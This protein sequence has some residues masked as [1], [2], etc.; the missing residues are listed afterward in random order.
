MPIDLHVHSTASD[1][2]SGPAEVVREAAAA[3]VD[4]LALT[5][6][7]TVAGWAPAA[8]EAGLLGIRLIPG[9]EISCQVRGVSVHLLGYLVDPL[10]TVLTGMWHAT[11]TS[12]ELRARRIVERLAADVPV[13]W[14]DVLAQTDDV[15]TIGRPHIAD[16]LVARGVVDSR[17]HAFATLLR[18]GSP[19]YARYLAPEGRDVVRAVVAAGGAAVIAHPLARRRGRVVDDG[20]VADLA[21]AGM[22]G[23]EVDHRDH[24]DAERSHLRGLAAD[25]G[26]VVTGASDYHGSGKANRLGEN[27]THP[28]ALEAILEHAGRP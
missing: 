9:V 15:A 14:D 2:R 28:E 25:L 24:D 4:T 11:R 26:L 12:R 10:D 19:Y 27:T 18:P 22:V 23:L 3:G 20:D 5:D 1:G 6:H 13:T 7:D 16:A 17:D 21:A 8:A